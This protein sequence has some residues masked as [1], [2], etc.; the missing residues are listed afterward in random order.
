MSP[1]D[2]TEREEKVPPLKCCEIEETMARIR[3]RKSPSLDRM[4]DE[5]CKAIPSNVVSVSVLFMGEGGYFPVFWKTTR[6]LGLNSLE[7]DRS[8]PRWQRHPV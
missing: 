8:N 5:M 2:R 7:M 6:V 4:I 1:A 3:Y